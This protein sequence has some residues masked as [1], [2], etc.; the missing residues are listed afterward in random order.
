MVNFGT[1]FQDL[2]EPTSPLEYCELRKPGILYKSKTSIFGLVASRDHGQPYFYARQVFDG[3]DFRSATG[4]LQEPAQENQVTEI[5]VQKPRIQVEAVITREAGNVKSI[6]FQRLQTSGG[7]K[8]LQRVLDFSRDEAASLQSF[9]RRLDQIDP[10]EV[11]ENTRYLDEATRVEVTSNEAGLLELLRTNP[12]LTAKLMSADPALLRLQQLY[13]RQESVDAFEALVTN[14]AASE[15][16]FQK[17]FEANKWLMGL[18]LDTHLFTSVNEDKLEQVTTGFSVTG[19]GKRVD[20]LLKTAGVIRSIAFAEIKKP[21]TDL[22]DP[23]A[24]RSEVWAPSK[25]LGGAVVQ[26]QQTIHKALET[27]AHSRLDVR[28]KDGAKAETLYSYA[29]RGFVVAGRLDEFVTPNGEVQEYRFRAFESF[30]RSISGIT[31]LTYDEVLARAKAAID[32]DGEE[33]S[34]EVTTD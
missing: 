30:R 17:F 31:I 6:E 22:I 26:V 9:F 5:I 25:E 27:I 11:P 28:D 2:R 23:V 8:V 19:A 16:D 32:F 1:L 12:E 13:Q 29:P 20:A 3:V 14:D 21:S 34:E 4:E 18:A 7:Q 24:Y 10:N 15:S 33:Q